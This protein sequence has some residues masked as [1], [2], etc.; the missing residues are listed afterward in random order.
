MSGEAVL[1]LSGT[2]QM[3]LLIVGIVLVVIG[4]AIWGLVE[5]LASFF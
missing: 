1:D 3:V 2:G 4:L 5:L